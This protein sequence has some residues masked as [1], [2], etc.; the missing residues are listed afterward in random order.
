MKELSV[1]VEFPYKLLLFFVFFQYCFFGWRFGSQESE[2]KLETVGSCAFFTYPA[3]W[4]YF[5]SGILESAC[6]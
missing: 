3:G 2:V 5:V 4:L 6:V 1:E